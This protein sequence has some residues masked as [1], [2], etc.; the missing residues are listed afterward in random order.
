[1]VPQDFEQHGSGGTALPGEVYPVLA[2]AVAGL[3]IERRQH[4]GPVTAVT[5]LSR[6]A[7]RFGE[8]VYAI[9]VRGVGNRGVIF[10]ER[11]IGLGAVE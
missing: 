2:R 5:D 6:A 1:M 10:V 4:D 11:G 8:G 3:H 7:A 9:L